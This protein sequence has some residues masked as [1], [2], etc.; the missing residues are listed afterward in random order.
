[1]F[2]DDGSSTEVGSDGTIYAT[3]TDGNAVSAVD[4]QNIVSYASDA[5]EAQKMEPFT[6]RT[7]GDN[8]PWYERVAEF[9][10]SRAIDSHYQSTAIQKGSQATTY[11]GQ[12]GRT[13]TNGQQA[14]SLGISMPM[15]LV[16]GVIALVAM[17]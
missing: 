4:R 9:G 17:N 6:A 13:Y 1:M 3:D 11:A 15:L 12:D 10:L 5:R 2:Y 7:T 8:R 14:N 16:I